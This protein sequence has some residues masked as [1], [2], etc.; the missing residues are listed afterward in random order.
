MIVNVWELDGKYELPFNIILFVVARIHRWRVAEILCGKFVNC[1]HF[2]YLFSFLIINYQ[3]RSNCM[4]FGIAVQI[5][6]TV[7]LVF[8]KLFS[9]VKEVIGKY[10]VQLN[11]LK[12]EN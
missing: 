9:H 6:K 4:F 3:H 7:L 10:V 12:E 5:V 8:S 1:N 2:T 11:N